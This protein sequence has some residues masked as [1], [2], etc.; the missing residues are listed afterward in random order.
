MRLF[1]AISI[2]DILSL[3]VLGLTYQGSMVIMF[4]LQ[5]TDRHFYYKCASINNNLPWISF[6]INRVS[7]CRYFCGSNGYTFAAINNSVCLCTDDS[8][9][10]AAAYE[11]CSY[12]LQVFLWW[13]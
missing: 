3:A 2:L 12:K 1:R 11:P 4:S 5:F 6:S 7:D 13:I 10:F 8:S 9:D